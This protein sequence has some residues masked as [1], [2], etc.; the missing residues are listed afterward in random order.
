VEKAVE[1]HASSAR[2]WIIPFLVLAAIVGGVT[3]FGYTK[4]RHLMKTHLL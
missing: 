4:Y 2:S 3:W 1:T